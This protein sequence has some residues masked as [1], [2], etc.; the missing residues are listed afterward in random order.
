MAE[1]DK[2]PKP[3]EPDP[4]RDLL[5]IKEVASIMRVDPRTVF[6]WM[7]RGRLKGVRVGGG[8]RV[9]RQELVRAIE[10]YEY[11]GGEQHDPAMG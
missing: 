5:T 2:Q 6:R 8:I 11:G 10:R 9:R 3:A 1:Q 4:S 7:D